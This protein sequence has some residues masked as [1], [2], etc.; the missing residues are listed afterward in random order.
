MSP[1]ERFPRPGQSPVVRF[2]G[3]LA[4]AYRYVD[5][6]GSEPQLVDVTYEEGHAVARFRDMEPE[7]SEVTLLVSDMSGSFERAA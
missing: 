6:P 4:G 5:F 3:I 1:A 7:D 2:T